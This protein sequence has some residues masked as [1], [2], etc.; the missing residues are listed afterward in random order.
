MA[1]D[2]FLDITGEIEGESQDATHANTIDVLA[3]SWGMSQSGSFHTGG[4]G[5]AGKANFQDISITKWVDNSSAELMKYC[6]NGDH[7]DEATL[8]VRK[9]GKKPLEYIKIKMTKVMVTSVS[10]GG[11]GGED[12]LTE[13]VS[14]N[15]A[16]VKYEYKKQKPDGTGEAAKEFPWNIA[17]N[18]D[19]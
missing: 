12:K 13:N 6:A 2:M 1:V 19:K 5:G 17:K 7:F 16:E 10:T 9:A 14:L 4:G 18:A 11:S 8:I 15:F 3:W